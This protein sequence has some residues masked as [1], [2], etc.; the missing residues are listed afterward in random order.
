MILKIIFYWND[1]LLSVKRNS[2]PYRKWIL[3]FNAPKKVA[4]DKVK[5]KIIVTIGF[6]SFSGK[7]Y[8]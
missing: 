3:T 8:A 7:V 1:N 5:A 6:S 2:V 4:L